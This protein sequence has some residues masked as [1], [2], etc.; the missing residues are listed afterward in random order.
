LA[1]GRSRDVP[2]SVRRYSTLGGLFGNTR[3][4]T[5]PSRCRSRPAAVAHTRGYLEAF[6]QV[7]ASTRT[8]DEIVKAMTARY[9]NAD[10]GV[11]LDLGAKV[12]AAKCRSGID[13]VVMRA[14]FDQ[15]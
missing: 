12:A 3:R 7:V 11:M 8:S 1:I 13:A 6:D 14:A 15:G 9:P 2:R 4:L 10:L 5:R